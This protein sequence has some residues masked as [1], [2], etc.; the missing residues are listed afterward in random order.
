MSSYEEEI[1]KK[2]ESGEAL[3]EKLDIPTLKYFWE[4]NPL[5]RRKTQTIPRFLR[6]VDVLRNFTDYELMTLSKSLHHRV[7]RK[8]EMIFKESTLG[9]GFY[10]I[11]NGRVELFNTDEDNKKNHIITLEKG[12]YFGELSILQ[13]RGYRNASAISV[14]GCELLGFFK[15]DLEELI[16]TQPIVATKLLHAISIIVANRFYNISSELNALK[17]K[18]E[19]LE[20]DAKNEK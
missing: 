9:V 18:V 14:D 12:E 19:R 10:F 11:F 8:E 7:F 16:N 15:P 3:P 20:N 6:K 13:E 5:V 4:A 17:K 1:S 2:I